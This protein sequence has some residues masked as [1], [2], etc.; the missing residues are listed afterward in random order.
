MSAINGN[1]YQEIDVATLDPVTYTAVPF[2]IVASWIGLFNDSTAVIEFSFDGAT[3]A[4]KLKT[5]GTMAMDIT[6]TKIWL[7]APVAGTGSM[8]IFAATKDLPHNFA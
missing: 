4:G 5:T 1:E 2:G 3:R 7:R 6:R 8:N